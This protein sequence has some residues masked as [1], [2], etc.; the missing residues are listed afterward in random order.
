MDISMMIGDVKFNYRVGLFIEKDDKIL[1]E[2][3]NIV[4]FSVLPGGRVKTL[5]NSVSAIKREIKEEMCVDISDSIL[6]SK[7]LIQSFFLLNNIKYHELFF[8]YKL[9]LAE[10]D[11][12]FDNIIK[13]LDSD[14]NYY[15]WIEKNKLKENNLLPNALNDIIDVSVFKIIF[16]DELIYN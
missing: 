5:E 11:N 6:E 15:K 16:L 12:R 13:N 4:N 2:C 3:S 7:A 9:K 8:V 1:I 10:D 14:S